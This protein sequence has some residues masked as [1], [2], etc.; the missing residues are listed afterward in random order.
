V[1][2]WFRTIAINA[3]AK[4]ANGSCRTNLLIGFVDSGDEFMKLVKDY[5]PTTLFQ[6]N[7]PDRQNL[8]NGDA[9]IRWWYTIGYGGGDGARGDGGNLGNLPPVTTGGNGQGGGSILPDGVPFGGSITD[10]LI[11]TN[12]TR[13][14]QS[15]TIVIDVNR[16]EGVPLKAATAFAAF[17]GLAEVKGT[18][19]PQS[20]SILNLFQ[21]RQNSTEL[22]YWDRA[23]L[24]DLYTL[25]LNRSGRQ[26]RGH[27]INAM[28]AGDPAQAGTE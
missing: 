7:G 9:P 21:D 6:V 16:A 3:G 22:S 27:L 4:L 18:A 15:A 12:V 8:A 13:A 14:I 23:F 11:R 1:E 19:K 5:R 2:G 24:D 26:Q 10:S 20:A 25:P 17:V 28:L